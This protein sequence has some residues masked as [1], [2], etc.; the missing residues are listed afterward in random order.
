MQSGI[1]TVP[2]NSE[3]GT[4]QVTLREI[5][6]EN[7]EPILSLWF[8]RVLDSYPA[9]TSGF[10][11]NPRRQFANPVG[12]TLSEGLA[13]LFDGLIAEGEFDVF[14]FTPVL[15]RVVRVRALQGLAPS[16]ELAF[17]FHLKQIV[18]D[19]LGD[20]AATVA[21]EFQVLDGRI[22]LLALTAFDLFMGCREKIYDLKAAEARNMTFRLLQ[23]AKLLSEVPES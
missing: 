17:I 1:G 15:D 20:R 18:R 10:M 22:D 6:S 16:K 5:L 8:D 4:R 9:D 3:G 21:G 7:R 14:A 12:Y 11:R 2:G 23:R 13:G 19:V